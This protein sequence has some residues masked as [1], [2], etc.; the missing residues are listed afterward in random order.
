M[1]DCLSISDYSELSEIYPPIDN[2][3]R[4]CLDEN[5]NGEEL[6]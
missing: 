3:Y 4:Y 6:F 2:K 1:S 5:L